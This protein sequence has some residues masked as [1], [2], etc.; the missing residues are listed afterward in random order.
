MK[1]ENQ[2]FIFHWGKYD[3]DP[4]WQHKVTHK[5]KAFTG[6]LLTFET[7]KLTFEL[8]DFLTPV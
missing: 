3:I 4:F 6:I 8:R 1:E 5:A 7:E 2:D